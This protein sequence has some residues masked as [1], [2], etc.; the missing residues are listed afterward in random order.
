VVQISAYIDSM[1]ASKLP[2]GAVAVLGY[3]QVISILPISLFSMSVSAAELPT[4]SSATGNP[5]QIASFLRQR[6]SAG[7]RRIAFFII[8]SA[9]AFLVLGDI[10]GAALYQTGR[11]RHSDAIYLWSVLAGSAVGLLATSLGRLYS[12]AFYALLDTRTPL[13]FAVIRVILTTALGL[14][15]AFKLPGWLGV[16]PKWGVAGL[17]ASAGVSGWVEFVLLRHAL[18]RRIGGTPLPADFTLKLWSI[19]FAGAGLG[20]LIKMAMGT[21]HP[22][23]LAMAVLPLYGVIYFGGTMLAGIPESLSALNSALRRTGRS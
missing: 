21:D 16:S 20:Y 4:L 5:E 8:P 19:A 23:L 10:I 7:L 9:V 15:C 14:L 18:G 1:I 11:F 2:L 12:S 17:T 6:L 13:R 3:A 22:R